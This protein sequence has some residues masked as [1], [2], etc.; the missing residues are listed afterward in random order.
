M[1]YIIR[2]GNGTMIARM[3][4]DMAGELISRCK[5]HFEKRAYED[6]TV[7][8]IFILDES[9]THGS[10]NYQCAWFLWAGTRFIPE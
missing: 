6:G 4:N 1:S 2:T 9:Y 3:T 7:R 10:G 5:G 8:T